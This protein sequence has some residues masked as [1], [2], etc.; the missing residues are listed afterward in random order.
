MNAEET[1]WSKMNELFYLLETDPPELGTKFGDCIP[2]VEKAID[3][4]KTQKVWDE[5][6]SLCAI[7]YLPVKMTNEERLQLEELTD[8]FGMR[9]LR[10]DYEDWKKGRQE[11]K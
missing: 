4:I 1:F 8:K 7:G 3:K 11:E 10:Q 2:A 9:T 6:R 5:F